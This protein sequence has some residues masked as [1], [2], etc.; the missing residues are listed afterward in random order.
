MEKSV[1]RHFLYPA[2]NQPSVASSLSDQFAFR[3]TGSITSAIVFLLHTVTQML[4][5][6]P[7]VIV[8]ATDFSKAFDTVR[9]ITLFEKLATLD[10]PDHVYNWLVNFFNGRTQCTAFHDT[11]S[12]LQAISASIVQGSAIGPTSYV[13][14]ASDLN[15]VRVGNVLCKYA[16]DTY[17]IIPSPNVDTR[18]EELDNVNNEPK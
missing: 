8:I 3:P 9:H 15:T 18:I 17:I 5:T 6:S 13:V 12:A 11:T 16:D 7:Y 1:V 4:N 10:L 2:F 14:N